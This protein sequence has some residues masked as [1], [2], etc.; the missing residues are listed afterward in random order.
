[1]IRRS[2]G[3]ELGRWMSSLAKVQELVDR[4]SGKIRADVVHRRLTAMG[5]QGSERST[6]RAVAEAKQAGH[7]RTYRPWIPE[8]GMWLQWDWGEGPR[9]RQRGDRL[10]LTSSREN[11]WPSDRRADDHQPGQHLAV[12]PD[13]SV[14]VDRRVRQIR[15]AAVA[16]DRSGQLLRS[17]TC[18]QRRW[19]RHQ[20]A[21]HQRIQPCQLTHNSFFD[22]I[23][24]KLTYRACPNRVWSWQP[25]PD[26]LASGLVRL[27]MKLVG[28]TTVLA[29]SFALTACSTTA[30]SAGPSPAP[31]HPATK[32]TT[33]KATTTSS[34]IGMTSHPDQRQPTA[35]NPN[36]RAYVPLAAR[37]VNT[38]RPTQVIG[39]G[40]PASCTSAAVVR[41]VAE[42]GV[43]TFNCG[44]KPVIITMSATAKVMNT[45][46]R[47]V[48]DGGGLVTLSGG[49]T[50]EILYMDTCD[51]SQVWTTNHCWDQEWPQLVVQ[52]ITLED[53][54][55]P[56]E[57]TPGTPYGGGGGGAIYAEGGQLKVVDSRFIDNG[58]YNVGP[59]LGG[60][61]IRA[62]TQWSIRPVYVTDDTFYGGRCS[63]GSALSSLDSSWDVINSV[64]TDNEAIG[65]G[66]NPAKPGTPGGGSGG[67][68]YTDGD[69]YNV[70][71]E[72]TAIRNNS[73]REGGGGIF[74]VVDND[75][76]TLTIKDSTLH[77]NPSGEFFTAGYPGIFF[78]SSG[79]PIIIDSTLN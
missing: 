13:F 43:I 63:N 79:T 47:V 15:P 32:L 65:W 12:W 27:L 58:C 72:G 68:I 39:D 29:A 40:T 9:A 67:A 78:H 54:Y 34:S 70:L 24:R 6:R 30:T 4:S 14:V 52:H 71:I 28:P 64:M 17:E 46:H 77:N 35:G 49:G 55:S 26:A 69:D 22:R 8:P 21:L 42:G 3:G 44:P 62:I 16:T 57:Q 7:R 74:F 75:R 37:P 31:V 19:P 18:V 56:I 25:L 33:G 45:S 51:K 2:R 41:S 38:G 53:G 50:R 48:L 76:G 66:A 36:G 60:A 73:A 20:I 61:A 59:D 23:R 1:M 10:G 11:R 5:Y